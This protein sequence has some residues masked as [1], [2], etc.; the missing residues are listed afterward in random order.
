MPDPQGLGLNEL[1]LSP[2]SAEWTKRY[3][4]ESVRLVELPGILAVEHIGSTAIP[5]IRAK[6]IVDIAAAVECDPADVMLKTRLAA[7]GYVSLGEYGLPG[8]QF[9][10]LGDP[11]SVH[12]HVVQSNS[13]HWRDW[14]DFRNY[15][16]AHPQDA[17][18]YEQEKVRLMNLF[19]ED[20][21]SYTR[22]KAGFVAEILA[23]ARSQ[24]D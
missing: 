3:K 5:N 21:P 11:P 9:F 10:T 13:P 4:A 14:L 23:R 20:R 7:L 6:P 19:K 22:G 24:A 18:R 2:P 8:R 12:L 16:R 17:I 15:L 1:K